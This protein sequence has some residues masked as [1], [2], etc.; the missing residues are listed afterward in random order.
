MRT[1]WSVF[2]IVGLLFISSSVSAQ[3]LRPDDRYQGYPQSL[4]EWPKGLPDLNACQAL[5][6]YEPADFHLAK[7]VNRVKVAGVRIQDYDEC[8]WMLTR[9]KW[10]WVMR[11]ARTRHLVDARGRDLFDDGSPN[12]QPCDNPSPFGFAILPQAV[13]QFVPP[14][15][16]QPVPPP[17][18]QVRQEAPTPPRMV[19]PPMEELEV[20]SDRENRPLIIEKKGFCSSKTC[21]IAGIIG[22]AAAGFVG[23]ETWRNWPCPSGTWRR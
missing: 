23:Y 21:R 16:P 14:P 12:G 9:N 19:M 1:I 13:E 22:I 8:R 3:E 4:I 20:E 7:Y 5:E 15:P 10:R 2:A 6:Y 11:P 17:P 18:P